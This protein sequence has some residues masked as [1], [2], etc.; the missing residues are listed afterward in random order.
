MANYEKLYNL[1]D[2]NGELLGQKFT[3]KGTNT[4][5]TLSEFGAKYFS[6][7]NG[8]KKIYDIIDDARN[9]WPN[10]VY[11]KV[12]SPNIQQFYKDY[13]CDLQ[14]ATSTSYCA[15][16]FQIQVDNNDYVGEYTDKATKTRFSVR[17]ED[18]SELTI[19]A[20]G[21]KTNLLSSANDIFKIQL[22]IQQ[23]IKISDTSFHK[24][25]LN[26]D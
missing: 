1:K 14:W 16:N 15:G 7:A 2:T 19:Y 25:S 26:T 21:Q 8:V 23:Y 9:K 17:L 20:F 13:V 24:S 18:N 22:S 11:T 12:L 5:L 10:S 3:K 4:A 6:D